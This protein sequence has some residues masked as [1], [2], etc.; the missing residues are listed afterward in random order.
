VEKVKEGRMMRV[1]EKGR[2][3]RR[4]WGAGTWIWKNSPLTLL[5][6]A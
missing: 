5:N 6:F 4:R 2:R 3:G 1:K